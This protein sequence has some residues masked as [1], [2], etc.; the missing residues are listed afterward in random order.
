MNNGLTYKQVQQLA[1]D[2][3]KCLGSSTQVFGMKSTGSSIWNENN[4]AGTHWVKDFMYCRL[5]RPV[6][7]YGYQVASQ[8]NLNK[9]ER[10]QRSA[11][12]IITG[13]R[14]CC[15]K[16]NVLYEADLQPLPMRIRTNSAKYI[17]KLQ[18]LGSFNRT[19]KFILQ[20]TS[21]QR[22]KKDSPVGVM[23]K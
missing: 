13:L 11:A 18:S 8:T 10:V 23:W 3:S 15:P 19:S 6:L 14:S 9:L 22:L 16:A 17:A 12:R 20:W 2:Y 4:I 5:I 7:E 1:Y 21:N